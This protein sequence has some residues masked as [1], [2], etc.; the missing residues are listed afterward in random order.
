[1]IVGVQDSTKTVIQ[2]CVNGEQVIHSVFSLTAENVS[3]A[4]SQTDF[5]LEALN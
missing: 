2:C 3:S 4:R 1:M 5:V